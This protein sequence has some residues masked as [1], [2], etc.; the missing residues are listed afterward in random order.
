MPRT[1]P[2]ASL[3]LHAMDI[4]SLDLTSPVFFRRMEAGEVIAYEPD[5]DGTG[6]TLKVFIRAP[7]DQYVKAKHP[8]LACQRHRLQT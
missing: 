4:G 5:K 3:S 7:Y 1:R 2:A 6:V 8:L